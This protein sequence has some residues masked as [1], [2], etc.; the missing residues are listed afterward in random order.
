MRDFRKT[1]TVSAGHGVE[2][3]ACSDYPPCQQNSGVTCI[4]GLFEVVEARRIE[5]PL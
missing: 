2:L 4:N 5:L 1:K 3:K